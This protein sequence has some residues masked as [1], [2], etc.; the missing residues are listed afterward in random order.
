VLEN[1][2]AAMPSSKPDKD[3]TKKGQQQSPGQHGS[4]RIKQPD[5]PVC[6][7][8]SKQHHRRNRMRP[9][10]SPA[11]DASPRQQLDHARNP[12][13]NAHHKPPSGG[14]QREPR[15]KRISRE[16]IEDVTA[17]SAD[18]QADWK[19]DQHGMNGMPGQ[20]NPRTDIQMLGFIMLHHAR[21]T[22]PMRL[23][24]LCLAVGPALASC[25]GPFSTLEPGSADAAQIAQLWWVMLVGA[26]LIL[27]GVM[28]VALYALRESRRVKAV[29][30]RSMLIGGGLLFPFL[31]LS[32]LLGFALLWGERLIGGLPKDILVVEAKASQSGWDFEYPDAG[33]RQTQ[34]IL[35]VPAAQPFRVRVSSTD[36]IHS[37]WVPQLGGKID[38]IP[39]KITSIDLQADKPGRYRGRCAEYCGVRHALMLFDVIAH[40]PENYPAALQ[41]ATT[42]TVSSDMEAEMEAILTPRAPSAMERIRK[43][44]DTLLRWL[45]VRQ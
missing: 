26:L 24:F 3:R 19:I 39:G 16:P 30:E 20:S 7:D 29:S 8:D 14:P 31:T 37:F 6:P 5:A 17:K 15:K 38:A 42:S 27:A 18:C 1:Q 9:A 40:A 44:Y 35:H 32:L 10:F 41:A 43:N 25:T 2:F 12:R 4:T 36:V 23:G 28:G 45:G 22:Q 11:S 34:N 33:G 13:Q 21:V